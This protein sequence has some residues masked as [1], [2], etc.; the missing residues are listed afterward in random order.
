M[1]KVALIGDYSDSVIA[2]TAIPKAL[3]LA[4]KKLSVS[5]VHEWIGTDQ[6]TSP[7]SI[8]AKKPDAVWCVPGS[9][10]R[11]MQG[12]LD[13]I[14]F[15]REN[16]IP[17]LGTCGGF[18]HALVEYAR[19]VLNLSDAD[20]AES[21]PQASAPL[22]SKLKCALINQSEIIRIWPNTRLAQ[23]YNSLKV[24]ES[25]QCSYGFNRAFLTAFESGPMEFK[26]P[27]QFTAFS[28][29]LGV[30]AF[31]LTDHPFFIGTLFQPERS[32]AANVWHPIV[33][34]FVEAAGKH[35]SPR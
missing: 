7:G 3:D 10:Y 26:T 14:R 13:A 5:V 22:I 18:Q 1:I 17:F 23:V 25:Y 27:L 19:N 33:R 11:N 9:P 32:A 8:A 29:E 24:E 30:R 4:A 28:D 2:H 34:A 12:A 16:Q 6:I 20:H 31:E 15:A 35:N 21:N